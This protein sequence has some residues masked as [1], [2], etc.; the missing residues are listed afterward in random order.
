MIEQAIEKFLAIDYTNIK[1]KKSAP[2][3]QVPAAQLPYMFFRSVVIR[4]EGVTLN[5]TS[6]FSEA[7]MEM[8]VLVEPVRQNLQEKNY[9]IMRSIMEDIATK[10]EANA[11]DLLLLD[12]EIRE[13]FEQINTDTAHYAV[14][15]QI[16]CGI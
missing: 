9:T 14:I 2:P 11:K 3:T 13:G 16:R 10:F 15:A 8:V 7:S 4:R 12:Y 5:Y 6:G 1:T